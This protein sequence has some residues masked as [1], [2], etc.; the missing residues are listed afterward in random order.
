MDER[1]AKLEPA[2]TEEWLREVF[3]H[4]ISPNEFAEW[5]LRSVDL[6]KWLSVYSAGGKAP[7]H[8]VKDVGNTENHGRK[9]S[10]RRPRAS[11]DHPSSQ[12]EKGWSRHLLFDF[13]EYAS[14]NPDLEWSVALLEAYVQLGPMPTSTELQALC[15]F[16]DDHAWQQEL[17]IAKQKLTLQARKMG[18]PSLFPRAKTGSQGKRLHPIEPRVY[19]WLLEWVEDIRSNEPPLV[20]PEQWGRAIAAEEKYQNDE[21]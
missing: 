3:G 15:G 18:A 8:F 11:P 14:S 16:E 12:H 2:V 1:K 4:G 10:S 20:I 19:T 7:R 6:E 17:R 9:H 21:D 5:I 13:L